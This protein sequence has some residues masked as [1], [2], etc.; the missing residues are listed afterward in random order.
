MTKKRFAVILV[1][2]CA[3][4]GA[5]TYIILS[6]AA[7]S[8]RARK[9]A[10]YTEPDYIRYAAQGYSF[11]SVSNKTNILL[12]VTDVSSPVRIHL[13]TLDEDKLTLD[14]LD[15]PPPTYTVVDGFSGTLKSA[16]STG[17]YK[18]IVSKTLALK[19][20]YE[21]SLSAEALSTV[22]ELLGGTKASLSRSV[23]ADELS[24]KKGAAAFDKSVSYDIITLSDAYSSEDRAYLYHAFFSSVIIRF[25][26]LGAIE[27]VSKLTSLLLNSVDTDMTVSDM[28]EI[29]GVLS[30]VKLKKIN[31]Y[32][33]PGEMCEHG[34]EA[35]Y[36]AHLS[37]TAELLNKSFRV[38]GGDVG[39]GGL[40]A[41]EIAN[42][43]IS[44]SLPKSV[45]EYIK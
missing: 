22:T 11:D 27:S 30:A 38:K 25:G 15:V 44:F 3:I 43:G 2:A 45:S 14:I 42:S 29:A 37:E 36:S 1:S 8:A 16:Y 19:I 20:D 12:T 9:D 4:A 23:K 21:L 32:L 18:Q 34:G 40:G 28:I 13:L 10:R 24:L 33:L 7:V 5:I 41:A 6:I 31:I 39:S 35:V 26:D 17:V